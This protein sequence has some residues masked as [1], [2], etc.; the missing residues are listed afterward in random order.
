MLY[1]STC[2][3]EMVR[4]E[5]SEIPE[6]LKIII[7]RIIQEA[8]NNAAKYSGADRILLS[9]VKTGDCIELRIEDNGT[10]FD[11]GAAVSRMDPSGGFGLTSM[12]E[13][14]ELSGG[15]LE[16]KSAP[17]AGTKIRACWELP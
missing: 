10:G 15:T 8:M 17:G 12:K 13:R 11:P 14:A 5:E 4:I 3:E 16:I 2:V 1:S 7:F 9:L 6:H